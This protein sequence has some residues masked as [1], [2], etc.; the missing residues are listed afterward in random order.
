[1]LCTLLVAFSIVSLGCSSFSHNQMD[2]SHTLVRLSGL[3]RRCWRCAGAEKIFGYSCSSCTNKKRKTKIEQK[4]KIQTKAYLLDKTNRIVIQ[5]GLIA[6]EMFYI[7]LK[8]NTIKY[9]FSVTQNEKCKKKTVENRTF[10][11]GKK[12]T[13]NT[14][15]WTSKNKRPKN[16]NPSSTVQKRSSMAGKKNPN[17]NASQKES[18][19]QFSYKN[20]TENVQWIGFTLLSHKRCLIVAIVLAK[21]KTPCSLWITANHFKPTKNNNIKTYTF[22]T[23][24]LIQ[25]LKKTCTRKKT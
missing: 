3:D 5:N 25:I 24:N 1:M 4:G 8:W 20:V 2:S 12:N 11:P 7:K 6:N 18:K 10:Y 21:T 16:I 17:T 13:A 22:C 9:I 14:I 19:S 15:S 23:K